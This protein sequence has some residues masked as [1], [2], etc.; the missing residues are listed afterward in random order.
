MKQILNDGLADNQAFERNIN[1]LR[2]CNG[3][4]NLAINEL[5]K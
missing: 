3:D 1:Q 2:K 5:F 4:L